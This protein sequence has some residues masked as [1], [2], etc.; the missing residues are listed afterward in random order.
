MIV[1]RCSLLSASVNGS[2]ALPVSAI[3]NA[4]HYNCR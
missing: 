2:R 3:L 4:L 1:E